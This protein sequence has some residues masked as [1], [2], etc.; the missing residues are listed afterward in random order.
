MLAHSPPLPLIIDLAGKPYKITPEDE[1]GIICALRKRDRVRRIRLHMPVPVLQKLL[2]AIGGEFPLLEYLFISPPAK[3]NTD[4]VVPK[5]FRAPH[6][7]HLILINFALPIQSP[8]LTRTAG[9]VMLSLGF[10]PPS[11]YFNPGDLLA[12]LSL[13]PQLEILRVNFHSPIPNRD[14]R[15]QLFHTPITT[16]VT[17]PNLHWFGFG[18]ASAYLEA[19]LSR[20]TTPL[21]D[22]L[23]VVFSHQ[24]TFSVPCLLHFMSTME[25]L[26]VSHARLVF[27]ENGFFLRV[28]PSEEARA[29][30]F[31][32]SVRCDHVD[33][34][35]ASAVQILNML[36]PSLSGVVNLILNPEGHTS[37]S[38]GHD[39]TYR[40]H[41]REILR[42][43]NNVKTIRV[44]NGLVEELSRSLQVNGGELPLELL[45]E[46]KSLEYFSNGDGRA[47]FTPFQ[48]VRLIAGHPVNLVPRGTRSARR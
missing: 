33:W 14:V 16:H 36:N 11:V 32:L 12:R 25:N 41:W 18:G 10:I 6:L 23:Q 9:L 43:F 3:Q 20:M 47:A 22:K 30:S 31:Y 17:L 26:R 48:D 45:P 15:R 42:S 27:N 13:M 19:L 29:Y 37:L 24:L 1:E 44:P 35:V 4:L 8:L 38:E 7:R 2:T 28:Y 46:L 40:T 5:T 34:Q 21:L 39:E